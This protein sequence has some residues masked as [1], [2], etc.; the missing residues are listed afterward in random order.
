[1][2]TALKLYRRAF[3]LSM[4]ISRVVKNLFRFQKRLKYIV[5][6]KNFRYAEYIESFLLYV[7]GA[8]ISVDG[9]L[10]SCYCPG[11][12]LRTPR[13]SDTLV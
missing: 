3:G 8:R 6:V 12:R 9:V 11:T 7:G 5:Y 4:Y 13:L 10:E 2:V 1:M